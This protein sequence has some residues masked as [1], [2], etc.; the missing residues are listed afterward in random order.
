MYVKYVLVISQNPE[1]SSNCLE[2]GTINHLF[3]SDPES[4]VRT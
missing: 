2:E 4:L 3:T 1:D